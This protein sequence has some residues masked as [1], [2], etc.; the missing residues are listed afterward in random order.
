[1]V[2]RPISKKMGE[3]LEPNVRGNGGEGE[4]TRTGRGGEL[5]YGIHTIQYGIQGQSDAGDQERKGW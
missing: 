4:D 2:K 5:G 1:M 3:S